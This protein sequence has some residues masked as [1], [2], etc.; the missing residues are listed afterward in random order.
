[1]DLCPQRTW[2]FTVQSAVQ[3]EEV[4]AESRTDVSE[5]WK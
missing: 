5:V 1:M 2:E 3:D 4:S